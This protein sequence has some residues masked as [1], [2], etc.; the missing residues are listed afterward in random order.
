MS[1]IIKFSSVNNWL[2]KINIKIMLAINIIL[3]VILGWIGW[4]IGNEFSF[5]IFYIIPVLLTAWYT[6]KINSIF[7]SFFA[8]LTWLIGDLFAGRS[9]SLP[10][11]PYINAI[12]RAILFLAFSSLVLIVKKQLS[13]ETKS[14]NEDFITKISNSR[15]FFNYAKMEIT[16]LERYKKSFTLAYFDIDNFKFI[17]DNYGHNTGNII[18]ADLAH[19]IKKNIRPTDV[20]ARLG[21]DEFAILLI[22]TSPA[23]ARTI[24]EKLQK[25]MKIC[26]KKKNM[27]VTF[28]FGVVTF[29]KPPDSVDDMIKKADDLMYSA[30][31]EGKD[32]I[33]YSVYK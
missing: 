21:G 28:S 23:Q 24:I 31:R 3:C 16:R 2:K 4:F 10:F 14:A 5:S 11:I 32:T 7:I 29:L 6:D 18:L 33:N 20:V 1:Q 27:L 30:K 26:M 25:I 15:A 9:Y 19:T 22:E 12:A 13:H 17:N 8:A